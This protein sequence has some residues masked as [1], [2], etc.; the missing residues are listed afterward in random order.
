[1]QSCMF[2]DKQQSMDISVH[3]QDYSSHRRRTPACLTLT[4]DSDDSGV[5][6]DELDFSKDKDL[7]AKRTPAVYLGRDART[8][9]ARYSMPSPSRAFQQVDVARLPGPTVPRNASFY[10]RPVHMQKAGTFAVTTPSPMTKPAR[11]PAQLQR[12]NSSY[13]LSSATVKTL[14]RCDSSYV[15]TKKTVLPRS[16]SSY[17]Y[18][19]P[20]VLQRSDSSYVY[21]NK[22][23][24]SKSAPPGPNS[25][26]RRIPVPT[27]PLVEELQLTS[28]SNPDPSVP[29]MRQKVCA[30]LGVSESA[31]IEIMQGFLGGQNQ[32]M[33]A[34]QDG[35]R[36][37]I[38]KLVDARRK[39]RS[40]PTEA[41]QFSKLAQQHPAIRTDPALAFPIKVFCCRDIAGARHHDLIVMHRAPGRCFAET[42]A[43]KW[44]SRQ[45]PQLLQLFEALG[46]FLGNIHNRYQSQHGD[47]QPSN[48]FYD[49]NSGHFT[50]IDVGG[51]ESASLNSDGDV[52]HFGEA[53]RMLARGL[54]TQEL[55]T[56]GNR[57]FQTGYAAAY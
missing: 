4:V 31:R 57:Y 30:A 20:A 51:M 21:T 13:L 44:H 50:L 34:L 7:H 37:L 2:V 17:V 48:I 54:Q 42:I 25:D 46:R 19:K 5:E 3:E 33:W 12:S 53:L 52:E 55:F 22:V 8:G 47:F 11:A 10:T 26:H 43:Q 32:G 14:Q 40:L 6:E 27:G 56:D 9:E 16:D 35:A 38:I 15:Q 28:Y 1:M 36:T 23:T 39:H 45:V 24:R 29:P 18:T 41:E 49:D